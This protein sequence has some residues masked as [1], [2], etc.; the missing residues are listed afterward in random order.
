MNLY[1]RL[2]KLMITQRK[3]P[4][5]TMWDTART[6]FRVWPTDLDLL[7]HM[8]NGRYLTLL[9][10]ARMDIMVRS[11]YWSAMSKKG[12]YPVVA[13]QTITYRRSL[14]PFMKFDI[15]TRI[16]GLNDHGVY[17]EQSFC[18]GED[19]YAQA[20]IRA[21]FLK[22][23]GGKVS[24]EELLEFIGDMPADLVLPEWIEQWSSANRGIKKEFR[25]LTP[26]D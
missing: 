25:S 11:G 15:Y 24:N 26:N 13:G 10:L 21:R 6:P 23:S 20:V 8:N 5:V 19:V 7:G 16:I 1:F 9:D 14:N 4:R 2:L 3:R 17:L 18:V 12:W 22:K